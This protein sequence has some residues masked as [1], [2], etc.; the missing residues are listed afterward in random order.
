MKRNQKDKSTLKTKQKKDSSSSSDSLIEDDFDFSSAEEP[1]HHNDHI[2][3]VK[4]YNPSDLSDNYDEES[5][6]DDDDDDDYKPHK[7]EKTKQKGLKSKRKIPIDLDKM[8]HQVISKDI[9]QK[10]P[11]VIHTSNIQNEVRK[12]HHKDDDKVSHVEEEKDVSEDD[13]VSKVKQNKT[14]IISVDYPDAEQKAYED[15]K[16]FLRMASSNPLITFTDL[17]TKRN[18][19]ITQIKHLRVQAGQP[20][21][22]NGQ[23]TPESP[24]SKHI[25]SILT[26]RTRYRYQ[27]GKDKKDLFESDEDQVVSDNDITTQVD[28]I[29]MDESIDPKDKEKRLEKACTLAFRIF[30][31]AKQQ[32]N[33]NEADIAAKKKQYTHAETSLKQFRTSQLSSAEKAKQLE[34]YRAIHRISAAK[35]RGHISTEY[36]REAENKVYEEWK[37]FLKQTASLPSLTFK[38]LIA[39]RKEITDKII[40]IRLAANQPARLN[41]KLIPES[42]TTKKKWLSIRK[43]YSRIEMIYG[44]H[45]KKPNKN[46]SSS[47]SSISKPDDKVQSDEEEDNDKVQS[48]DESENELDTTDEDDQDTHKTITHKSIDTKQEEEELKKACILALRDLNKAKHQTNRNEADIAAKKLQHSRTVNALRKFRISKLSSLERTRLAEKLSKLQSISAAKC[49]GTLSQEYNP[50]AENKVYQDWKHYLKQAQSS[51]S[52]TSTELK[53]KR[54]E[55]KDKITEIRLSA[56]QP[57]SL[58]GKL[59]PESPRTYSDWLNLYRKQ[60]QLDD[61][62]DE[63][64]NELFVNT[65]HDEGNT[66]SKENDASD[67]ELNHEKEK[68]V[69]EVQEE[70]DDEEDNI[71]EILMKELDEAK[72]SW[73]QAVDTNK[74]QVEISSK[75]LFFQKKLAEYRSKTQ[76]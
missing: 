50:E 1:F 68:E 72:N 69:E 12:T 74:T 37:H 14:S 7:N 63:Q 56:G 54:K 25:W 29:L 31:K 21:K 75:F 59:F 42:P 49:L 4:F 41:D 73:R 2:D 27:R 5:H 58:N 70:D 22:Q 23:L 53:D 51:L 28:E 35:L 16:A 47:I 66:S 39:K 34:R 19:F 61:V 11:K 76:S 9:T 65:F 20:I 33:K 38:T 71:K 32:T 15:W 55:I 46:T 40:D 52:I 43:K 67:L 6:D 18:Q 44:P 8:G 10:R 17:K 13:E 36:N 62:V 24:T 64:L 3:T 57:A 26:Q 30:K 48:D 60:K 45:G